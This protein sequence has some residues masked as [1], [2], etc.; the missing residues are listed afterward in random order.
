MGLW[1][2][3]LQL[4]DQLH[5]V[6][7]LNFALLHLNYFFFFNASKIECTVNWDGAR[8]G[9]LAMAF[10]DASLSREIGSLKHRSLVSNDNAQFLVGR[11]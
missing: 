11:T 2:L 1:P 10:Q 7:F 9:A 5:G 3:L 4:S 8:Q 6:A